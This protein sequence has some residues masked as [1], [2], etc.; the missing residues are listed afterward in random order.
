[1]VGSDPS[2]GCLRRRSS[3]AV[4]FIVDG[5]GYQALPAPSA[6]TSRAYS[7]SPTAIGD[8]P[9]Y[10]DGSATLESAASQGYS[11]WI[12]ALQGHASGMQ[13]S[14]PR[15]PVPF[16]RVVHATQDQNRISPAL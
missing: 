14:H 1:M 2:A 5:G 4:G 11:S 13:W 9:M 15:V 16:S 3:S 8:G 10:S 7:N 12:S 6:T